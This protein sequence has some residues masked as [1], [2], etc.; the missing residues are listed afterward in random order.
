M[1]R[2]IRVKKVRNFDSSGAM[3]M[4]QCIKEIT[5]DHC[6]DEIYAMLKEYSMDPNE[7]SQ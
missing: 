3:K 5:G 7:T 6:E 4:I 2:T 1:K